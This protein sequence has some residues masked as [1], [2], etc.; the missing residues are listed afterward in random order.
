MPP[1]L[2]GDRHRQDAAHMPLEEE[3]H[4]GGHRFP[5][6]LDECEGP[7]VP[8]DPVDVIAAEAVLP[9][10]EYLEPVQCIEII[11]PGNAEQ[12]AVKPRACL[13]SFST[14]KE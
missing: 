12:G 11:G 7:L 10:A 13:F 2:R 14:A 4:R 6:V 8:Q 3:H 1:G 9:K 5:A